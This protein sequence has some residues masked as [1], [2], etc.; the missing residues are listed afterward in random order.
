MSATP[1]PS[2]LLDRLREQARLPLERALS[3]PPELYFRPEVFEIERERIF[4]REWLCV[5]RAGELARPGDWRALDV[6]GEPLL[7]AR[8]SAGTLHALSR[9]CRHRAMDLTACAPAA[10][11]NAKSIQCPYHLWTYRL[12]GSLLGAPEME[13]AGGFARE[14]AALPRFALEQW[15]GFVFV[16]LDPDAAPLASRMRAVEERLGG[17]DLS[18]WVSGGVVEWGA[19]GVNWKVAIENACECYHHLGTHGT[20]LQPLWPAQEVVLDESSDD[21]ICGH[22]R[23]SEAHSQGVRDGHRVHP[24]VLPPVAGMTPEQQSETLIVGVFPM[25]FFALSPDSA[26]WFRWLPTGPESHE[27]EIHLLVPP[28]SPSAPDFEARAGALLDYVRTIQSEDAAT[29]AGVQRGA[30][31]RVA[32]PGPLSHHEKP[33]WQFQR[34]LA[35][36]LTGSS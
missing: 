15:Q 27:L 7:L 31:S 34:W 18:D 16:N 4:S 14:R 28:G 13:R 26:T 9:V 22:L 30:R 20:T 11:G 23:V 12:D 19:V 17:V 10:R 36:R 5:A 32:A 21:W 1:R 8:D 25:F 6:A 2:E 35:A 24:T 29:N 33:L 3:L